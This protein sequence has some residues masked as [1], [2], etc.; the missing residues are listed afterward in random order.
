MNPQSAG[1]RSKAR[2]PLGPPVLTFGSAKLPPPIEQ[3][4]QPFH[5]DR[6]SRLRNVY[7]NFVHFAYLDARPA[8]GDIMVEATF[9]SGAVGSALRLTRED[10]LRLAAKL[11]AAAK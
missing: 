3:T 1:Q 9:I 4:I 5:V 11:E 6:G 2:R 10:A 7:A 8:G